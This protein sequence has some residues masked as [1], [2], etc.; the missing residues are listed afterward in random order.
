MKR[1]LIILIFISQF[2][3]SNVAAQTVTYH[4]TQH[5]N[6]R[7]ELFER[8]DDIDSTKIVMLGN[9]LTE[10]AANFG[11]W[12]TLLHASNVVNRGISGD[13]AQGIITRLVQI[14]PKKPKAIFLMC[15]T[16]DL[17]HNLTAEQVFR[18]CKG[19]IDSIRS[20][21]K[22][23]ELYVQSLLPINESFGR[24]K[25][26]RGRTDD[27]PI[28]NDMLRK[29]CEEQSITFVNLFPFFTARGGRARNV[30]MRHLSVDGLHLSSKGY[31]IWA[32]QLQRFIDEVNRSE[33]VK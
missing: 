9:S 29:Y 7:V 30:L 2:A 11:D 23:T 20:G 18:K 5:Y 4:F 28:I 10:N 17:S 25:N 26:L 19:V 14:L 33:Y 13:D 32:W 21:A 24:W 6:D 15:G 8:L 12:S 22:E 1:I 3:L 31:T 27:I 16:N